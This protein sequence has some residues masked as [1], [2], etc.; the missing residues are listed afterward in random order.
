MLDVLVGLLDELVK[1]DVFVEGVVKKV[2][3]YMVDVLEDS[4]DKVQENLL[5]S[6]VDL[7]IYIIRFQWDMVKYLI[8]QFL[9]NIF[10]I[11]VKGVIQID[12]DLKFWVFVY[13][14]LKG[15]FQNLE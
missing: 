15:N 13:N 7:V 12:N 2:V 14:N 3:Q 9:K 1:L 4:K 5:V 6:G 8:K 10:E 11:I